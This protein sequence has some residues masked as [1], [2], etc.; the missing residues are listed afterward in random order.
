MLAVVFHPVFLFFYVFL[1][2][3]IYSFLHHHSMPGLGIAFLFTV[4][5]PIAAVYFLAKDI[6]LRH[7]KK[8]FVPL[9]VALVGYVVAFLLLNFDKLPQVFYVLLLSIIVSTVLILFFNFFFKISMHANAYGIVMFICMIYWVQLGNFPELKLLIV[10]AFL[11]MFLVLWQ[12]LNS[13]AHTW[14]EII[15]GFAV[16]FISAFAVLVLT[17]G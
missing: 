13:R 3:W 10:L 2:Y 4:V 1:G 11:L 5:I 12:R 15:S 9:T 8:R 16:G 6:H 17:R 14:R 7:R